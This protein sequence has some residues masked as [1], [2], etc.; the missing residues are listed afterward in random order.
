MNNF[1][2]ELL[3][4]LAAVF[5]T[6]SNASFQEE[7]RALSIQSLASNETIDV[8][9][10]KDGSYDQNALKKIEYILRD[11]KNNE[12][13][14]IDINLIEFLYAVKEEVKSDLTNKEP[15]I[16][17]ISGYRTLDSNE[18]NRGP[19]AKWA[20][21][22]AKNSRHLYG[23]AIDFLIPGVSSEK[24]RDAAWCLQRGGVGHYP[25]IVKETSLEYIH[26][27]TDRVRF[28]GSSYNF[29]TINCS[30]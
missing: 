28:W 30:P 1:K 15:V 21:D 14:G 24:L 27:D 2:K 5:N 3:L 20:K 13:H 18:E 8:I 9:Y 26:I 6:T 12:I 17:I 29:N 23:K 4:S 16:Q 11:P 19:N 10:Y 7:D 22:V 25:H